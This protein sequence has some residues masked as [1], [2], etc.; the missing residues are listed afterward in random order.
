MIR[1]PP[2][3]TLFPYTTLF[4]SVA[5]R[6]L[7]KTA[8]TPCSAAAGVGRTRKGVSPLHLDADAD[9]GDQ[10]V[11]DG[12]ILHA[13]RRCND[14]SGE[15][16]DVVADFGANEDLLADCE[17]DAAADAGHGL[18]GLGLGQVAEL[19]ERLIG[20]LRTGAAEDLQAAAEGGKELDLAVVPGGF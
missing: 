19:V 13:G 6:A 1:R 5:R 16:G 8:G 7:K 20:G 10:I 15:R 17:F 14:L 18:H 12:P 4:R 2:R 3:S 11:E 9:H